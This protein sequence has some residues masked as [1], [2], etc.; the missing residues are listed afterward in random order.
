MYPAPQA[1]IALRL[2][3]C[4]AL[5]TFAL[6]LSV[7]DARDNDLPARVPYVFPEPGTDAV[8]DSIRARRE[9]GI[10]LD[11]DGALLNAPL[12]AQSWNAIAGVIRDNNTIPAN[13]RE[14]L[15]LRTAV[16]NDAAYQWGEHESVGRAAGLTTSHLR[17]LRLAPPFA[18]LGDPSSSAAR[19][20][21]STLSPQLAAAVDFADWSTGAVRIPQGVYDR[22]HAHL[23]NE[24]MVEAISTVGF[25]NFVSRFVVGLDLDSKANVPVPIPS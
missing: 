14:L 12:I 21:N 19:L 13:M 23:S 9:G 16:L 5:G 8:A 3:I 18:G 15:I 7:L 1:A 22:L 20:L 24:Q 2:L 4:L 25:Y 17:T 6:A 11:L 10:L